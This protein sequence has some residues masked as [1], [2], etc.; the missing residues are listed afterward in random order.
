MLATTLRNLWARKLRL[1]LSGIAIVLGVTFVSG[2]MVFTSSLASSFDAGMATAYDDIDVVVTGA[3]MPAA[4]P[5]SPPSVPLPAA[6]VDAL[7]A[8]PEVAEVRAEIWSENVR[9]L[10][11]EGQAI[12]T[13]SGHIATNWPGDAAFALHEGRGPES[14]DEVAVNAELA[15]VAGLELGDT[16]GVVTR[17]P[18]RDVTVVGVF[19]I[20]PDRDSWFGETHVAFTDA[21]AQELLVGEPDV[22]TELAIVAAEDVSVDELVELAR[23]V[24]GEGA[25]AMTGAEVLASLEDDI[26]EEF[27]IID[28]LLL[29]FSIVALIVGAM[30]VL[31]T[32]SMLVAQRMRE[33]ALLRAV[34]A[35]RR[36]VVGSVLLD[37]V[38]VGAIA[39]TVGLLLGI[40]VAALLNGWLGSEL[41]MS[42]VLRVPLRAVV[43][44][45]G[46]GI[47]VTAVAALIPAVRASRVA[48]VAAMREASAPIE[49]SR[50]PTSS[51]VALLVI[52]AA[53]LVVGLSGPMT[54]GRVALALGGVA[55]AATGVL[56]VT[57]VLVRPLVWLIGRPLSRSV[58]ADLGRR[59]AARL[60]KR[61][62]M[63]AGTLIVGV[64][65]VT[66]AS[67]FFGSFAASLAHHVD[68]VLRADLVIASEPT[69]LTPP[70]FDVAVI[71]EVR[72]MPD[73]A[74]AVA[75]WR[76]EVAIGDDHDVAV[77]LPDDLPTWFT[78]AG[79]GVQEGEVAPLRSGEL[80]IGERTA[81]SRGLSLGDELVVSLPDGGELPLEVALIYERNDLF[82]VP[83]LSAE[84]A[85]AL[86]LAHPIEGFVTLTDD[87][88]PS[89]VR[90]AI[91]PL[92]AGTPEVFVHDRSG[93]IELQTREYDQAV[94]GVQ[95]LLVLAMVIAA[96]GVVNTLVL[97]IVERTRELGLLRAIGLGRAAT[98]RM[99]AAESV[100]VSVFGGVIGV[101][102]GAGIGAGV[103]RILREEGFARLAL[104][105]GLMITYLVVAVI[106]GVLASVLPA[107]R[108]ARLDVLRAIADE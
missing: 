5:G 45:Y 77:R 73:V 57:P 72:A 32:F 7:A 70:T 21:A 55:T 71:D 15:R 22:Y 3:P 56:V 53:L 105:W 104:P 79:V 64:T 94:V 60:P 80:A 97:S 95:A 4:A 2:A 17:E 40:G 83:L 50:R 75:H 37:A 48:P 69:D 84:D 67:T 51:G 36:Q 89:E 101:V 11:G 99:V 61:T 76:T 19:G 88:D 86:G 42:P 38:V 108:A 106:I 41:Q 46:V 65:L 91:Q 98:A 74:A 68:G 63:T 47:V 87:A 102:T 1:L 103:V 30:L 92:L 13:L 49:G 35:S 25:Q 33:L 96:L 10:D 26:R 9:P 24:V 100:I 18:R 107:V 44:A 81:D 28:A 62:A 78:M 85:D 52:G 66:A 20:S 39:A 8:R 12:P 31:N 23:N 93:Y 34:G 6:S 59:N 54:G 90:A 43:A 82:E 29:G 27:A 58:A 16:F 14:D